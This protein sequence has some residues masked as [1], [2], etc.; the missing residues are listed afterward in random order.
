MRRL[1]IRPGAIGDFIVSLPAMEAL[2]A[3]YTEVWC[4]EQNVPLARFADR[5]IS[6]GTAGIDRIGLLNDSDVLDR[7]AGFDSIV[8]WYGTMNPAFRGHVEH[9]PFQF[10]SALPKGGVHAVQFYRQQAISLG[11][12]EVAHSP[13]LPCPSVART[14]AAHSEG[15]EVPCRMFTQC[16][17]RV[18]LSLAVSKVAPPHISK[19]KSWGARC[20]TASATASIS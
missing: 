11:A 2:R 10:L 5:A 4:A 6:L 15:A 17:S 13:S 20:A 8:S 9:L 3:G 16:A 14:F 18:S 19:E 1:L 12:R 7:L